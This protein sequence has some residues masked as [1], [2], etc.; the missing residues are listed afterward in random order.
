MNDD[1]ATL[2]TWLDA[3][4]LGD[5]ELL[6]VLPNHGPEG[7]DRLTNPERR[8]LSELLEARRA[9]VPGYRPGPLDR[10]STVRDR[11]DAME[12]AGLFDAGP[13]GARERTT[14]DPATRQDPPAGRH[15]PAPPTGRR[16]RQRQR[17][18]ERER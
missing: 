9:V 11:R 3:H 14:V 16:S 12:P 7:A 2:R 4:S 8:L 18:E 17:A 13:G 5:A 6:H 1:T 10:S 15:Q